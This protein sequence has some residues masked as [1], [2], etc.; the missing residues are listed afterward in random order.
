M[1]ISK[2]FLDNFVVVQEWDNRT[3]D[4]NPLTRSQVMEYANS[5]NN[6]Q[7]HYRLICELGVEFWSAPQEM[8]GALTR[9]RGQALHLIFGPIETL[10][11]Q[12]AV[13]ICIFKG[14]SI[15]HCKGH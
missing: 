8:T 15:P 4:M 11:Q 12:F 6:L 9:A 2:P 7:R 14:Y 1:D 5:L 3:D 10:L 13:A